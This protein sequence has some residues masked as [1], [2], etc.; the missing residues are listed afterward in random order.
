VTN[1]T[2]W[3]DAR[4]TARETTRELFAPLTFVVRAFTGG[5]KAA[6]APAAGRTKWYGR[7]TLGQQRRQAVEATTKT[8]PAHRHRGRG[9]EQTPEPHSGTVRG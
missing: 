3:D 4:D 7:Q 8:L 6:P 5:H 9:R 2:L 1:R